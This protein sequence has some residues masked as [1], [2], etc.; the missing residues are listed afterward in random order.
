MDLEL[1]QKQR[2]RIK[3]GSGPFVDAEHTGFASL[4]FI[5][6]GQCGYIEIRMK[7][8]DHKVFQFPRKAHKKECDFGWWEDAEVVY[9]YNRNGKDKE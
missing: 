4:G 3:T 5:F 2:V 9:S 1:F 8:G 6:H 7:K